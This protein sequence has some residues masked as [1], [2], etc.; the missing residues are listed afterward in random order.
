[1]RKWVSK[2]NRA[3]LE[4][5]CEDFSNI[6]DTLAGCIVYKGTLSSGVEIAVASS[7]VTSS[8]DWSNNAEMSYQKKIDMLSRV[9]HKNFVNLISYCEEDEP[10]NR[11]MVF[12][13]AL[14]GILFEHLLVK[15]M[16]HLDWCARMRIIMGIAYCLQYMHHDLNPPVAHSNLN[17]HNIFLT[18]DYAAK[19]AEI[20]F[21][22]QDSSKSKSS[23]DNESVHSTLPPLL[24]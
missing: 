10:F 1:M 6:I 13:Y 16:E 17:S 12:E 21:L 20:S 3:E 4:T 23:S 9:N 5:A 15:K 11:M 19:I 8:K 2:L 14:N 22:P 7:L 24:M 18:N